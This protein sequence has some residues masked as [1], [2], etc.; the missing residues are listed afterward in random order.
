MSPRRVPREDLPALEGQQNALV[1]RPSGC[2]RTLRCPSAATT[3]S[4]SLTVAAPTRPAHPRASRLVPTVVVL[5]ASLLC[6]PPS[7]AQDAPP[8]SPGSGSVPRGAGGA[9]V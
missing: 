4:R 6:A 8:D 3:L 7:R 5:T 9:V 2:G 1:P